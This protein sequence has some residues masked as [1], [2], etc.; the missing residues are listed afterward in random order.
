MYIPIKDYVLKLK[1]DKWLPLLLMN[2]VFF[3]A[4][5][6]NIIVKFNLQ[7]MFNYKHSS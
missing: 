2:C 5:N 3:H 4:E 1:A 7:K 6:I